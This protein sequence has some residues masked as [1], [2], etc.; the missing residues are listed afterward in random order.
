MSEFPLPNPFPA[1]ASPS[2]T[3]PMPPA[4]PPAFLDPAT[5]AVRVEA[6]LA[7]Y[8]EL[9]RKLAAISG[10]RGDG[11]P[12]SPDGYAI[13]CAHGFFESDPEIN[14][15]LHAAGFAPHQ[16]QLLYDL[17]AERVIPMIRQLAAEFEADRENDRL[18]SH[19]GGADKWREVSRQLTAWAKR[20]LPPSAME[21]LTSSFDGVMALYRM[22]QGN[23]PQALG[24]AAAADGRA[25][26]E[27]ELH[28]L[29][30]DPRYWRDRDQGL[31]NRVTDGFRR[32]Y[33]GE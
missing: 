15:K 29:M 24:K 28:A 33:P 26:A 14:R 10:R 25:M 2:G 6:L 1:A 19:F 17:A 8:G 12:E 9:E 23:E 3:P 30:R 31:I 22:M 11:C 20:N 5:G 16:A 27:G 4:V 7:A 13:D 21:G 32:L 18:I